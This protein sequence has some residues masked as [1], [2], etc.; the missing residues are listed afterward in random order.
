MSQT[1]GRLLAAI[2]VAALVA[3]TVWHWQYALALIAFYWWLVWGWG[4]G[5]RNS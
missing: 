1:F 4:P 2:L 3:L 5:R